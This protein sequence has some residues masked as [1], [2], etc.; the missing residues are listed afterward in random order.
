M[1]AMDILPKIV[2]ALWAKRSKSYYWRHHD[3][4][5]E[6]RRIKLAANPEP[7]RARMRA[8]VK[9]N[10]ERHKASAK[11]RIE[12]LKAE[13][14]EGF[15]E[16]ERQRS[17]RYRSTP[18][19]K[20]KARLN[21]IRNRPARNA[22]ERELRKL[23][24]EY[25]IRHR[26]RTKLTK[27]LN[28]QNVTKSK[29]ALELLGCT[30]PEF[31]AYMESKFLPGMSWENHG[32]VWHIDHIKPCVLFDLRDLEQQKVCFHYTNLQPLFALDNLSK[33]RFRKPKRTFLKM[34]V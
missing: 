30:L 21:K 11:A 18:E 12:R 22:R 15:R 7:N 20:E 8:W 31:F 4:A 19:F 17:L 3:K 5:R 25:K 23:D 32:P 2:I 6:T 13:N 34:A 14:L 24:P 33:N 10:P 27:V 9:A 26:L 16:S 28:V 29:S 1:T